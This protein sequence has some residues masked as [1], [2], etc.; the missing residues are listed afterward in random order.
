VATQDAQAPPPDAELAKEVDEQLVDAAPEPT[1]T[2]EGEGAPDGVKE[3]TETDPLKARAVGGY[4]ARLIAWFSSRFHVPPGA[5]P[6]DEL[7][8]LSSSVSASIS[9]DGS[10]TGFSVGRPS[11]NGVF[12]SR[13]QAAMQSA[14][15]QQVPPPPPLY[16]DI[17]PPS[18]ALNFLGKNQQCQ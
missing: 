4:R 3:G 16:P 10:V 15:G 17:L 8:G 6:C 12:D 18:L 1:Q 11:G 5:V 14:V 2:P 9:P 13:V 7:K